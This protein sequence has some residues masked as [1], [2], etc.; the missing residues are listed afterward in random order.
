MDLSQS[1]ML[2]SDEMLLEFFDYSHTF[3]TFGERLNFIV[4][5]LSEESQNSILCNGVAYNEVEQL[6]IKKHLE[7]A[8]DSE[9]KYKQIVNTILNTNKYK[10]ENKGYI[11][12]TDLVNSTAKIN[13]L[14]DN[15][16]YQNVLIKHNEILQKVIKD[17]NG[18]IIKNIGDAYLAIFGNIFNGLKACIEAQAEFENINK[19]RDID[20]KISVRMALHRGEYSL[21][22]VENNNIDVY[23][24]SINYT[25]R[26]IGCT[27]GGQIYVS[28]MFVDEWNRRTINDIADG[29]LRWCEQVKAGLNIQE[30][31]IEY[32]KT[33]YQL[34]NDF[35]TNVSFT[36]VGLFSFKGFDKDHELFSVVFNGAIKKL[37]SIDNKINEWIQFSISEDK[38]KSIESEYLFD[39]LGYLINNLFVAISDDLLKSTIKKVNKN[40]TFAS[41]LKFWKDSDGKERIIKN[42]MPEDFE[43]IR[44]IQEK[45]LPVTGDDILIWYKE[46]ISIINDAAHNLVEKTINDLDLDIEN[47]DLIRKYL[48]KDNGN[49]KNGA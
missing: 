34:K 24:S 40:N 9:K 23:G 25:A 22:I 41:L 36:S 4:N 35:Y 28:K 37:K 47:K 10:I 12:F 29:I 43:V 11:L 3:D 13:I 44:E 32:F 46:F 38:K 31:D 15:N 7:K 5:Y 49:K 18:R 8:R 21:K 6:Y 17:N 20:D 14:G 16:Y 33:I 27:G 48:L 45:N 42:I 30:S 19:D 2:C 39:N 26:M 1:I